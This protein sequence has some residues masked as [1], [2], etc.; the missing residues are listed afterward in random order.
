MDSHGWIR[1]L[2]SYPISNKPGARRMDQAKRRGKHTPRKQ[3]NTNSGKPNKTPK[4]KKKKREIH[5]KRK[6]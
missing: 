6:Q 2:E 4:K 1:L 5:I 3:E